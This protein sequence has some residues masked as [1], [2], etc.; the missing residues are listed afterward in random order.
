MHFPTDINLLWDAA[1]KLLDF[2]GDI[3]EDAPV[4][5]WRKQKEWRRTIKNAYIRLNKVAFR[6]GKHK[7]ERMLTAAADYIM[8]ARDFSGK[9]KKTKDVL[10]LAASGSLVKAVRMM[11]IDEFEKMRISILI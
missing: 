2:I 3:T 4:A 5:G 11:Q 9:L 7:E 10:Q 6:G 8:I 1:R